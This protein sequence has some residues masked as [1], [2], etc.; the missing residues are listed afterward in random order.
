MPQQTTAVM[1][2]SATGSRYRVDRWFYIG[3]AAALSSASDRGRNADVGVVLYVFRRGAGLSAD[4][5]TDSET[6]MN[7][8]MAEHGQAGRNEVQLQLRAGKARP[9]EFDAGQTDPLPKVESWLP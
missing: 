7:Q 6:L 9:I 1:V 5:G 8:A 3:A 4:Q 2:P